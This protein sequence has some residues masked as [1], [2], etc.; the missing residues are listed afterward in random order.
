MRFRL[1]H[2]IERV[3]IAKWCVEHFETNFF[4]HFSFD[5][6]FAHVLSI[7]HCDMMPLAIT[8]VFVVLQRQSVFRVLA[9]INKSTTNKVQFLN[10]QKHFD[11]YK[12]KVLF[13]IWSFCLISE[14]F[15]VFGVFF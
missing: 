10:E 4:F 14:V 5:E 6:R 7:Y 11:F 12:A 15:F 8:F 13:D 3:M 1:K 9:I 2:V